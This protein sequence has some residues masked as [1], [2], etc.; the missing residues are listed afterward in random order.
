MSLDPQIATLIA[1]LDAGFPPVHEMTGAQARAI[2]RSRFVAAPDP[3]RLFKVADRSIDGPGGPIP[4]R[5]YRP[6]VPGPLP[7]VVYAHGGGFVFCDLDSHDELCR[8]L[9]NLVP[10]VFVSVGY[11][12][13]P[14]HPWPAAAD[15]VY[16]AACWA[17]EN[18]GAIGGDPQRVV[19]GGDSAGGNLAAVTALMCRDR[20]TPRLAG[21]LLLYPVIAADFDNES[22]RLFGAGYYNPRPALRWYWDQYVPEMSDRD[23]PY[24]CPLAADLRGLPPTVCVIAGCDPLRDEAIAF[25]DALTHV[26]VHTARCDYEGGVHGF[27][28]M[29]ALDIA[30][31]ARRQACAELGRLLSATAGEVVVI[32]RV[33][34]KPGRAR[35]FVDAYLTGYAP[36]A[37]QRGMTLRDVLV[38][39]PIWFD[40]DNNTITI[41]WVLPSPQAWWE[42]T[43]QGRADPSLAQW[44]SRVAHLVHERRRS[45]AAAA[46]DVDALCDV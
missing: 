45:V 12:L 15:D 39:P 19:V 1:K 20:G 9:A 30:H 3:E 41:T 32:D 29:P 27:M 26:G 38:S 2:I 22:Y 40:D 42:M 11:R 4:I 16:A 34:T 14:E 43:W 36:R 31:R 33:V 7:V 37:R 10:A 25:L 46:R 23:H 21:Q 17:F 6:D 13:A 18:A 35:E 8:N 28:T 5:I 24:A 44:W